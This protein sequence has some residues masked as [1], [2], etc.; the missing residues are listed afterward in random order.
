MKGRSSAY[1]MIHLEPQV[2]RH[3][4]K[5]G[6]IVDIQFA[7]AYDSLDIAEVSAVMSLY[8]SRAYIGALSGLKSFELITEIYTNT[9]YDS[10]AVY[11][12]YSDDKL[13]FNRWLNTLMEKRIE[14]SIYIRVTAASYEPNL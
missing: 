13:R 11:T 6:E 3:K 2:I 5:I 12:G 4:D 9:G 7:I 14:G 10:F 8:S 1:K